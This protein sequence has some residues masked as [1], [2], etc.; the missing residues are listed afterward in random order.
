MRRVCAWCGNQLNLEAGDAGSGNPITHGI[1]SDCSEELWRES[2]GVPLKEFL[3][4]L[5]VPTF[6]VDGS[7]RV[8]TANAAGLGM[9]EKTEAEVADHLGGEVFDCV[10]AEL[11]GGC[12]QTEFCPACTVRNTVTATH[13]TGKS[14][15]R[16]PATLTIRRGQKMMEMS[17]VLS[18]EKVGERVW[19]QVEPAG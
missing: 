9:V 7:G 19:V 15:H 4:A 3:N 11:P 13:R 1:C 16:V 14:H 12:G 5:S 10:N 18:T 2:G 17:F 6:L 8:E